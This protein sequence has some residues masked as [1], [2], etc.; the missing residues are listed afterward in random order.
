MD[1][2]KMI[3]A[4][5]KVLFSGLEFPSHVM[6]GQST[7]LKCSFTRAPSQKV[8]KV[9]KKTKKIWFSLDQKWEILGRNRESAHCQE[10]NLS[11]TKKK[12]QQIELALKINSVDHNDHPILVTCSSAS[13]FVPNTKKIFEFPPLLLDLFSENRVIHEIPLKCLFIL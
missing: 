8:R 1:F 6:L 7:S 10:V 12:N 2:C 5:L 4:T 11:A 9:L 3:C 13:K